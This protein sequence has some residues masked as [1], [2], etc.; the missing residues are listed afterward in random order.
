MTDSGKKQSPGG[1]KLPSK[2]MCPFLSEPFDECLCREMGSMNVATIVRLC[3]GDYEACVIY[4]KATRKTTTEQEDQP[5][6]RT[7]KEEP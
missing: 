2:D 4:M 7:E 5:S 3:G 1:S 6:R